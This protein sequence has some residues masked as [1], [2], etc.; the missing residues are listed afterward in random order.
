MLR[1]GKDKDQEKTD[2][3]SHKPEV[4]DYSTQ[5]LLVLPGNKC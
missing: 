2:N 5:K 4:P 3:S 1:I